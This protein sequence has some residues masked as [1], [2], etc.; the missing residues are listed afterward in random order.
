RLLLFVSLVHLDLVRGK[1]S[2]N[3]PFLG[4]GH[5]EVVEGSRQHTGDVVELVGRDLQPAMG[6][7]QGELVVAR[8]RGRIYLWSARDGAAPRGAHELKA[9]KPVQ[10]VVAPFP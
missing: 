9:W 8:L 5:I 10:F 7:L 6:L 4:L 1:C 3:L 2:K